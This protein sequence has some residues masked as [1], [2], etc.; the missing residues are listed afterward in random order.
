MEFEWD[1]R[2]ASANLRKHGISFPFATLV[3]LDENRIEREDD[4]EGYGEER[5]ITVGLAGA[6][7]V[8]VLYTARENRIRIISARKAD[9]DERQ[10]YWNS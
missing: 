1:S 9:S 8:T 10:A 4:R 2:K 5:W 7:E 3:F 6:F